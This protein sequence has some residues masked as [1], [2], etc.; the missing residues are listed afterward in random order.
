VP[1]LSATAAAAVA[2]HVRTAALDA[3]RTHRIADVILAAS[4]AALRLADPGDPLGAATVAALGRSGGWSPQ[5]ARQL[6][7]DNARGWTARCLASIVF[8]ELEDPALLDAP[9]A[10]PERP[11]RRRQAV[12]PPAL[13]LVLAGNVPGIAVTAVIRG[14]LARSAVLCKVSRDEPDLVGLFARALAEADPALANTIA[15][16]WW[17]AGNPG[18]AATEWTKR[19]GKV[20]VY[21]GAD[22]VR[23]IRAGTPPEIP[24][25]EYGPRLGI[26]CLGKTVSDGELAGLAADVCAYDQ[27][28]CVSPRLVYLLGDSSDKEPDAASDSTIERLAAALGAESAASPGVSLSDSEAV[29]IRAARA[30]FQFAGDGVASALGADDLSWTVLYRSAPESYSESL[31]RTVWAYRVSGPDD[32]RRLGEVFE[33]RVQAVGVAGLQPADRQAIEELAVEW[34][35]SR[36]VR[37]GQMAWPPFDWRH[38]GRMQLM[39]LLNWTEFE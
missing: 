27:A 7:D 16:T 39:P 38:D 5:A 25:I 35:A 17:P 28:G 18:P 22:A 4:T 3:R 32:L 1:T 30:R 20:I 24:L 13:L 23:G 34:R 33:G 14:L 19:C 15:A 12:G 9:Q 2:D 36:V 26:A 10:D 37:V 8:S 29:A 21:G 31:P 11:G 6:L